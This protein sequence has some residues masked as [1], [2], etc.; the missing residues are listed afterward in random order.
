MEK[1]VQQTATGVTWQILSPSAEFSAEVDAAIRVC[2]EHIGLQ[3]PAITGEVL[4]NIIRVL[5]RCH[6]DINDH[7]WSE[8]I[9]APRPE[10]MNASNI[11]TGTLAASRVVF[12]DGS[13]LTTAGINTITAF[14]SAALTLTTAEQVI[15]GFSFTTVAVGVSDI[16]NI[17]AVLRANN[18]NAT[19][20]YLALSVVIDGNQA[21]GTGGSYYL[22]AGQSTL[23]FIASLTGLSAGSHTIAMYAVAPIGGTFTLGAGSNI[24][25]Q[26]IF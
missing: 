25:I 23:P 7:T 12:P 22:S 20:A 18:G 9:Y 5:A 16:Y 2:L 26:R 1:Q 10:C 8:I 24:I 17:S 14:S 15:P 4:Q 6:P 21:G 13:Q 11:T 3:H 19:F